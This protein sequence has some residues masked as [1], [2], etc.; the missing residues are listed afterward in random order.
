[1]NLFRSVSATPEEV[2]SFTGFVMINP[3]AASTS[4]Q[5]ATCP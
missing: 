1:M 3:V 2:L 4:V 5:I